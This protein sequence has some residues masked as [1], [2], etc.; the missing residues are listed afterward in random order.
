MRVLIAFDGSPGAGE[1]VALAHAVAWPP[2]SRLR[3][4]GVVEPGAWIPPLPRV[5]MTA[6]PILEPEL[7]AYLEEQLGEIAD[8]LAP[9]RH[10][11]TAILRGRAA[12]AILA[13]A[14]EFAA[15]VIIVGSRGHGPIASLVLGSVSAD[16]VDHASSPVL[17]ARRGSVKGVL[18][19]TDDSPSARAAEGIVAGWPIFDGLSIDVVSVADAVRPLT[20][21]IAPMFQRPA[22]HAYAQDI[23]AA[24]EASE[25]IA[26]E[27]A[28]RLREA[29]RDADAAV[30]R[31]DPA[32][33]IITL[34]EERQA[35]LIVIGSRGRSAF[36]EIVL[37]SVARNV[38]AGTEASVLVVRETAASER[39]SGPES[40]SAPRVLH[41]VR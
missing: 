24:V 32:A 27:A 21:G 18:I 2:Q 7:V 9:A 20:S 39:E 35:D 33:E 41:A 22:R 36:A 23:Q 16:V 28:S 6:A 31:G 40:S 14:R 29:G 15:D 17:V 13:D 37:G 12:D 10:V 26:S 25:R 1:A 11:E 3:I 30:G 38:L 5:A 8:R 19:A 4:V 34:A